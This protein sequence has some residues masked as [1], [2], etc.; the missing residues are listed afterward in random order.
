MAEAYDKEE[1][2]LVCPADGDTAAAAYAAT[3]RS[4]YEGE[5][6]A[7]CGG[8]EVTLLRSGDMGERDSVGI[9]ELKSE[10]DV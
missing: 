7:L 10:S 5:A 1:E 8:E 2:G 3:E 9:S 6:M 4:M